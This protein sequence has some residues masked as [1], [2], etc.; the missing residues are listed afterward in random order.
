[1]RVRKG[2][3]VAAGDILMTLDDREAVAAVR[4]AEA[5]L[6]EVS[7]TSQQAV[8]DAEREAEVDPR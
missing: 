1:V 5:A 7:A 3:R 2:D 4:E 6:A 8:A